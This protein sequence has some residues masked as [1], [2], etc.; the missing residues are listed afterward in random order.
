MLYNYNG[1]DIY[2]KFIGKKEGC[3]N[4][5]LHGWGSE[6]IHFSNIIN[7]DKSNRWLIVDFPPFGK[8]G[9]IKGWSVYTY[10]NMIENLLNYLNVEECNIIGHSFGGRIGIILASSNNFRYKKLILIDS[11]GLKPKRKIGYHLKI[12]RY[13]LAKKL[14]KDVSS[15][16]SKDYL[17]LD[18]DMREIFISVVNTYL[19]QDCKKITIPTLIVWG[20]NDI[21][22]P[23]YMAYRFRKL[24][25]N[26]KLVILKN[27]GH[28]CFLDRQIEFCENVFNFLEE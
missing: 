13:K 21:E 15:F 4:L 2:Y 8:S 23:L 11:A 22:T 12:W 20:E 27:A 10:A 16:G 9:K 26:S 7:A 18:K 28:F 17:G 6:G 1:C 24:I 5:F 14:G 25:D 19:D 3:V